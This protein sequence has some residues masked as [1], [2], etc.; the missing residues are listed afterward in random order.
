MNLDLAGQVRKLR[1]LGF[2]GLKVFAGKPS[3]QGQLDLKLSD[4]VFVSAFKEAE[5]LGLKVLIQVADP[6]VF[7][8][9]E[10]VSGYNRPLWAGSNG[11]KTEA[12]PL[13]G[14]EELQNQALTISEACPDLTVIFPQLL[15]M[16]HDLP[17][18]SR[19][20]ETHDHAY[21]DL[22][23]G[24]YFYGELDRD[25]QAASPPWPGSAAARSCSC[26]G[27]SWGPAACSCAATRE[28][29]PNGTGSST[30][31]RRPYTL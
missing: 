27:W 1:H 30:P 11:E 21:L 26:A 17:R 31:T 18:F 24:L 10:G 4:P 15:M 13:H 22:A 5:R 28:T 19:I 25:R 14:Y 9:S 12:N 16:A 7:W 20:L 6:P 3:F 2:E 23:P 8:S 29:D